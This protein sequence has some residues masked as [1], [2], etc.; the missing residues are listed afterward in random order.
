MDA[1][2]EIMVAR[3]TSKRVQFN[4]QVVVATLEETAS[5]E[6]EIEIDEAKIDRM[7]HALH[8]ADPTGERNDPEELKVLEG[9][10]GFCPLLQTILS[11]GNGNSKILNSFVIDQCGA[12]GPLID[13]ELEKLDRRHAHLTKLGSHLIESLDMYRSLMRE[14][15]AAPQSHGNIAMGMPGPG[16]QYTGISVGSTVQPGGAMHATGAMKYPFPQP[17]APPQSPSLAPFAPPGGHPAPFPPNQVPNPMPYGVV[18]MGQQPFVNP[19]SGH[20]PNF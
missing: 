14:M 17:Q 6:A 19:Y 15:P 20:P 11:F 10:C 16:Y 12:M 18:N 4:E 9:N 5:S 13:A 8:E 7:L 3:E 2:P 1:E